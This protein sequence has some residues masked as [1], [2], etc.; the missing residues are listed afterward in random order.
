MRTP[1]TNTTKL[2]SRAPATGPAGNGDST[3]PVLSQNGDYVA[4]TSFATDLVS[5][6]TTEARRVFRTHLPTD[7]TVV[8]SRK[9]GLTGAHGDG[10]EASIDDSGSLIA[11]AS[12]NQL[13]TADT[14][15]SYD[16]YVRDMQAGKTTLVSRA[17]GPDGAV[18]GGAFESSISGNG[19]AVVFESYA[20]LDGQDKDTASNIY[21]RSLGLKHDGADRRR[22]RRRPVRSLLGPVDRRQQPRDRVRVAGDGAAPRRHRPLGRRLREEHRVEQGRGR[23]PRA[24]APAARPPTA[25]RWPP[26]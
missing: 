10:I 6:V 13:D 11:F 8:A 3:E 22:R 24:T 5:G 19:L 23:Q 1:G 2:V 25:R 12:G 26:R 16:I 9:D 14:N 21:R 4:F 20:P 15:N 7:F 17:T 18:G